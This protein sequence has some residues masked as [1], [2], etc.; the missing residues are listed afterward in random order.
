MNLQRIKQLCESKRLEVKELAQSAHMSEQNLHRCIR[1]NKIQAENLETI[2][3]LLNVSVVEFFDEDVSF[4]A[5]KQVG[6]DYLER[7]DS[8]N[9]PE[10]HGPVTAADADLKAEVE[11]LRQKLIKAQERIIELMDKK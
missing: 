10:Y 11:E 7:G 9:G 5:I 8:H 6:R 2:A 1:L 3:R 4:K